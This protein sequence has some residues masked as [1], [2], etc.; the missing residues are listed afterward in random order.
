MPETF[1]ELDFSDHAKNKNELPQNISV[2]FF[3]NLPYNKVIFFFF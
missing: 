2:Y 1:L 3:H